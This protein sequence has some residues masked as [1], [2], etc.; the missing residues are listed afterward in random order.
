M[1]HRYWCRIYLSVVG[2]FIDMWNNVS[3]EANSRILMA[4]VVSVLL[5]LV[6]LMKQGLSS[7]TVSAKASTILNVRLSAPLIE[8]ALSSK[9]QELAS[10]RETFRPLREIESPKKIKKLIPIPPVPVEQNDQKPAESVPA[11]PVFNK[12][13]DLPP[14]EPSSEFCKPVRELLQERW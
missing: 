9:R 11:N 8:G 2:V 4:L 14:M 10:V 13:K 5:H 12:P 1:R 7:S 6:F 3:K